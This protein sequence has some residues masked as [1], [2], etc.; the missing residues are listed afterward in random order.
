MSRE[1]ALYPSEPPTPAH[2]APPDSW[3]VP[4]AEPEPEPKVPPRF[5]LAGAFSFLAAGVA[6]IGALLP[7]ANYRDGFELTG[8][9]QGNGWLVLGVAVA[10]AACGGAAFVGSTPAAVRFGLT[11]CTVVLAGTFLW[12][13]MRVQ[14]ADHRSTVGPVLT[15]GGLLMVGL[16]AL[17]LAAGTLLA[18]GPLRSA[19]TWRNADPSAIA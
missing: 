3:P 18:L 6:V 5:R 15:G 9:D 12:N 10:A 8:I 14:D 17:I 7:W 13:R 19:F 4:P 16:S 2:L 1:A 11:G